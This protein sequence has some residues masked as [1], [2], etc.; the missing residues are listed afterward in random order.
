M[1]TNIKVMYNPTARN[2]IV[3]QKNIVRI[4]AKTC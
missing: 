1:G 3:R 4:Q 2:E